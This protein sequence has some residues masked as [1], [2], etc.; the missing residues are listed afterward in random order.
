MKKQWIKLCIFIM[1]M[2]LILVITNFCVDSANL[3]HD[4][5][6]GVSESILD[7]ERVYITSGN[8]D[9]RDVKAN[10][11]INM[12]ESVD[13][14]AVGPS[15]V[16]GINQEIT[17]N[18]SF[19]NLGVSRAGYYDI[20][21]QFGL[22]KVYNKKVDRVIFCVDSV[23]FDPQID[24][25][26]RRFEAL[27]EYAQYM[28]YILNS[29]EATIPEK[30][31]TGILDNWTQ[32]FSLTYFQTS[33]SI[34]KANGVGC[35]VEDRYG[36]C[37]E[38]Y[39]GAY[40]MSDASWIYPIEYQQLTVDFVESDAEQRGENFAGVI[41][42]NAYMDEKRIE[43]FVKLVEYL[44]G[45]GIEVEFYL[46]PFSPSLW[47]RVDW[48]Q[49]PII[50]ELESFIRTYAEENKIKVTGAYNPYELGMTDEDFLD[51]RHVRREALEK[52]F[53]FTE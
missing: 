25:N 19:Y 43:M 29:E 49:Y 34:V 2:L 1:P 48:T 7:G 24:Q 17:G 10:L 50:A 3:F 52:Y 39:P 4:V 5:S 8:L 21:A 51:A 32:L 20:L 35:F 14:V 37:E 6:K 12:P 28:E 46:C 18:D 45:K 40:Y 27:Q 33:M 23:F 16:M 42:P 30:N 13:C 31:G 41:T 15:L 47:E 36:I 38:D 26:D 11:I 9:E 22:M 44:K 53:D